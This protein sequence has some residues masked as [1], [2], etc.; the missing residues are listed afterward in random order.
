MWQD[1][2]E[3]GKQILTLV[4]MRGAA[5]GKC[6]STLAKLPEPPGTQ[7]RESGGKGGGLTLDK[8][9]TDF[10]RYFQSQTNKCK[11]LPSANHNVKHG[12]LV[13]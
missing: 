4:L 8:V 11:L 13:I 12:C 2:K 7:D 5:A 9:L 6:V 1:W 10:N 3:G